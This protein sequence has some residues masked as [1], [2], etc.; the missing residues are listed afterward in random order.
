MI[1]GNSRFKQVDPGVNPV[2]LP[3]SSN[4]SKL[5]FEGKGSSHPRLG[6]PPLRGGIHLEESNV[7][8]P[9]SGKS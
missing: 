2:S 6:F 5:K 1:T 4:F 7:G 8:I 9:S 3:F